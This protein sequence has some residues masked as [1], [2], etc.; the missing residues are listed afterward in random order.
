MWALWLF[1]VST[2]GTSPGWIP[3][4]AGDITP[5]PRHSMPTGIPADFT[6]EFI[7]WNPKWN[8]LPQPCDPKKLEVIHIG[9]C[10][11]TSIVN[12]L[13]NNQFSP[14]CFRQTHLK[15]VNETNS[16]SVAMYLIW[17]RDP[18]Q[19]YR[20]AHDFE[21]AVANTN[22]SKM[23]LIHKN[24]LCKLGPDCLAPVDLWNKGQMLRR[25]RKK[26]DEKAMGKPH[27]DLDPEVIPG[28]LA[29]RLNCREFQD[30]NHLAESLSLPW[31]NTKG[32]RARRM[33]TR[34]KHILM[35]IGWYLNSG[36]FIRKHHRKIFVGR[37]E[38]EQEDLLRLGKTLGLKTASEPLNNRK[39]HDPTYHEEFSDLAQRNLRVFYHSDYQALRALQHHGLLSAKAV[40]EYHLTDI[41]H[42]PERMM[43]DDGDGWMEWSFEFRWTHLQK[44]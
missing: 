5:S 30:A 23:L 42:H 41:V 27:P 22:L 28:M 44:T 36:E 8:N 17:L 24:G 9:K 32:H 31:N 33:M 3:N 25:L 7:E 18:L 16:D 35:G 4:V 1:V 19:R 34:F 10:G 21:C 2:L 12:F 39:T 38:N 37:I 43:L 40:A 11:G 13:K 14:W 20:S 15:K 6:S 26:A 29:Q